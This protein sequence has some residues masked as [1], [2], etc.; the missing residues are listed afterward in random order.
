MMA[1]AILAI[2]QGTTRTKA[3]IF[4]AEARCLAQA[5]SEV[6]LT[7][8]Q[9]GWVEQNPYDLLESVL[10]NARAA[11]Q[12]AGEVPLLACGLAN[13]G[14][15]VVVWHRRSG[16]PLYNA[17]SWQDR[18][19]DLLC[20][21]LRRE[22]AERLIRERTGLPLDPYFSAT[23]IRWVLDN[24]AGARELATRGEL[25]AGTTD[26]WLMWCLL[27]EHR[28]DETTASRTM[29]YNPRL[30][31]WD[32]E[33]LALL[34]IPRSIL[35]DIQP[36]CSLF[37][38]IASEHFGR[39]LPLTASLVDQQAALFGQAC[40]APNDVKV[41]YGTGAFILL[42]AGQ[43]LPTSRHGLLPTVAWS[44]G[45]E[46]IYALDG[47]IYVAGAA[48]QWLRDIGLVH[49]PEETLELALSVPDS[50]GV[51]FVPALAGLA[52]PYWDSYARGTI[53]GLTR[54]TTRA[55]LVR[56][57]LEGIAFSTR[58]VLQAMVQDTGRPIHSLKVDGGASANSFLMQALADITGVEVHIAAVQETT[59]LG[60]AFLA[61]I[62]AGLWRDE[63]ETALLWREAKVYRPRGNGSIETL[64]RRWFNAVER[65]RGWAAIA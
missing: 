49:S 54:A 15:T 31:D 41:T 7:Y 18:R 14:E 34:E 62:G 39:A 2:D 29:L 22:G 12:A 21:Q 32:E 38:T 64:Y 28:T 6:P 51:F 35:P 5:T 57:T 40:Y 46:I 53:V 27:G 58:D 13:Q 16:Q 61:G 19:T 36:S 56:A 23:K 20:E 43:T 52:A 11:I 25:L 65:A 42:N 30:R 44:R 1:P 8:P 63:T 60:A 45:K 3:L 47:G 10:S 50:G 9:P 17:I 26:A 37:G 48:I 55:H 24:V 59:A 4:D 33:V